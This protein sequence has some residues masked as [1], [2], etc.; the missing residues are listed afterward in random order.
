[1]RRLSYYQKWALLPHEEFNF[2]QHRIWRQEIRNNYKNTFTITKE[3]LTNLIT[4]KYTVIKNWVSLKTL[5]L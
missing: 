4:G 3:V 1:M 5:V 2:I